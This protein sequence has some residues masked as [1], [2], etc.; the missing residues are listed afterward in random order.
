MRVKQEVEK[1][2]MEQE[3]DVEEEDQMEEEEKVDD[4]VK[5]VDGKWK[6]RS[7]IGWWK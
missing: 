4:T 3:E 2:D 5:E 7:E 1:A 6:M